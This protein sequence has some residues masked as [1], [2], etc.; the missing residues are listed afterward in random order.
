VGLCS[1][2]LASAIRSGHG[3]VAHD[4]HARVVDLLG[5]L[6]EPGRLLRRVL[7]GDDLVVLAV[8]HQSRD[9]E[10][11]QVLR[12]IGLG[13]GPNGSLPLASPLFAGQALERASSLGNVRLELRVGGAPRLD[14]E[15]IMT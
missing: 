4:G 6:D 9:I 2:G 3:A 10:L 14:H 7:H 1:W 8:E 13:E 15:L 5:A 12:E 11:L